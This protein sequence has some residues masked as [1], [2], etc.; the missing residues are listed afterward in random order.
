VPVRLKVVG[1]EEREES[2]RDRLSLLSPSEDVEVLFDEEAGMVRV[3]ASGTRI[4][5]RRESAYASTRGR[6]NED[7]VAAASVVIPELGVGKSVERFMSSVVDLGRTVPSD[8][9]LVAVLRGRDVVVKFRGGTDRGGYA[10]ESRGSVLVRR[11]RSVCEIEVLTTV[12]DVDG[13]ARRAQRVW[14]QLAR[15]SAGEEVEDVLG[16]ILQ[17]IGR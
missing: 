1:S 2:L 7:A 5:V 13:L 9:E 12:Q 14:R 4:R 3:S 17:V 16:E 15:L 11:T 6:I 10:L 8:R